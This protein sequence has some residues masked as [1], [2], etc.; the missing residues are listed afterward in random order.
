MKDCI[1]C[2][3]ESSRKIDENDNGNQDYEKDP[4]NEREY[5]LL[6]LYKGLKPISG[7]QSCKPMILL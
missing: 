3:M 5:D 4:R 1:F 6:S 2:N 7:I